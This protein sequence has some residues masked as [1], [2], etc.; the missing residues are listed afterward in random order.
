M[1]DFTVETKW[2]CE[3]AENWQYDIMRDGQRVYRVKYNHMPDNHAVA[4]DYTCTCKGYKFRKNCKH[5]EEAKQYHCNWNQFVD[6]GDVLWLD[7][8]KEEF[9]CPRCKGKAKAIQLAV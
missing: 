1:T 2:I 3:T 6:G 5:I 4:Y 8:S 7:P 9:C